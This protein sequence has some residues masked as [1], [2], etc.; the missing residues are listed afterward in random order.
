MATEN[1]Y[2]EELIGALVPSGVRVKPMM[3]EYLV[4]YREQYVAAVCD[5]RLLVK[6]V[7]PAQRLLPGAREELPYEGAKPMLRVEHTEDKAF[8]LRLFEE[9]AAEIS[10]KK[11][12]G[13]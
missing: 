5:N 8:L 12:K 3:G 10:A 4:Y 1:T 2:P 7:C 11:R 13:K 9:T 6:N